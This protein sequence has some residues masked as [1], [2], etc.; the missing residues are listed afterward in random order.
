LEITMKRKP[1][2]FT[3]IELLVVVAIIA[4]LVAI[5]LPALA[6]ARNQAKSAVCMSNLRQI[7]LGIGNYAQDY[8]GVM[9]V[10]YDFYNNTWPDAWVQALGQFGYLPRHAGFF[11]A[12]L[13]KG[14][15]EVWNC[16]VAKA[17]GQ[18]QAN[19]PV[20]G[21]TYLRIINEPTWSDSYGGPKGTAG[22]VRLDRI[23]N[24][25]RQLFLIDGIFGSADGGAVGSMSGYAARYEMI[26]NWPSYSTGIAGFIHN[27]RA[28]VL[29]S[30]W[31]I[32]SIQVGQVTPD[33]CEDPDPK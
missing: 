30:D 15:Q 31:H 24:P 11:N 17:Q 29:F 32:D 10:S 22:W 8:N 1:N 9:Y 3:L 6:K 16:P 26:I 4:V 28:N 12:E 25:S 7:S 2:S 33:M 14:N 20:I 21:W 19:R 27:D 23:E 18:S 13:D 5:L